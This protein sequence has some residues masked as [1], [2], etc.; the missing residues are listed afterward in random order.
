MKSKKPKV[1]TARILS[2]AIFGWN[3]SWCSRAGLNCVRAALRNLRGTG[4]ILVPVP[5]NIGMLN[6]LAQE[7]DDG[8][9]VTAL[10]LKAVAREAKK[11]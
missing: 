6:T 1:D 8:K 3:D 9:T 4:F 5:P 2:T 10:W 7:L 11:K